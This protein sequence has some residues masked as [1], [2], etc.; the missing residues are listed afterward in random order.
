MSGVGAQAGQHRVDV[1]AATE[2]GELGAERQIDCGV[3]PFVLEQLGA[4]GDEP[5]RG[6]CGTAGRAEPDL[7]LAL[8]SFAGVDGVVVGFWLGEAQVALLAGDLTGLA[9]LAACVEH[10]DPGVG[11]WGGCFVGHVGPGHLRAEFRRCRI[12]RRR[13]CVAHR[14]L[15]DVG[16]AAERDDPH[17][18]RHHPECDQQHDGG[19]DVAPTERAT[20]SV[21]GGA[22]GDL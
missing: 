4:R 9:A 3:R 8:Q 22:F 19:D 12:G 18:E 16:R 6:R 1:V 2:L 10:P 14:G 13:W 15:A 17:H 20:V 21:E 7:T 11:E 5:D